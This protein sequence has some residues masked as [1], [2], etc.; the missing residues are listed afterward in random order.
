MARE[1]NV[2]EFS[3]DI[4]EL[5][6]YAYTGEKLSGKLS[7]ARVTKAVLEMARIRDKRVIDV[8]CGDGTYT[9]ELLEA[10]AREVL[11]VDASQAAI[12]KAREKASGIANIRFEACDIYRMEAEPV[13]DLAVVRGILHHLY[14]AERAVERI[15]RIAREIVVVEPNGYNP[16]LK[17]IE[18]VSPYH[19]HHEEKSYAPHR[20]A[21]W[22]KRNGGVVESSGYIG[23]VPFFCPDILSRVLKIM[24]PAFERAPL[25][26]R[27]FCAQ[28]VMR[29]V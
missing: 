20:L 3:R 19:I 27:L 6:G 25:I 24:E 21:G 7:N 8:G 17:V 28:F 22:F 14:D 11:G 13:Y 12:E 15:M 26:N 4:E 5:G 16:I 9:M 10:G 1:R 23:L 18:K 2:K 29:V